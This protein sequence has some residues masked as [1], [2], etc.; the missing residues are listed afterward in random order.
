MKKLFIILISALILL[1]TTACGGSSMITTISTVVP[2]YKNDEFS[3]LSKYLIEN[4]LINE[5]AVVIEYSYIE[6]DEG[7]RFSSKNFGNV[8]IYYFSN[9]TS[10]YYKQAE[11]GSIELYG[12][13]H[14]T[15]ISGDGNFVLIY[16][17]DIDT[18]KLSKI[19]LLDTF[20]AYPKDITSEDS[21]SK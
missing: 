12:T 4:K 9:K 13:T 17:S 16:S 10:D 3:D 20:K 6:A 5:E 19:N 7:Y 2:E 15:A 21:S 8:E 18:S 11:T 14:K 1:S